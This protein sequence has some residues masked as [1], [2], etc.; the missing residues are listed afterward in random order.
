MPADGI[1][2]ADMTNGNFGTSPLCCRPW[3]V[4]GHYTMIWRLGDE[5]T[6]GGATERS[7]FAAWCTGGM[8]AA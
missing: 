1:G 8:A 6:I 4:D 7:G 2:A 3:N 5:S